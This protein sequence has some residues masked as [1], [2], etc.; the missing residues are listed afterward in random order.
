M[1]H[2]PLTPEKVLDNSTLPTT[3]SSIRVLGAT[4]TRNGFLRRIFDPIIK[5]ANENDSNLYDVLSDVSNG[6]N[7]LHK[8]GEMSR[9]DGPAND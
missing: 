9:N 4:N 3:I 2:H 1:T 6:V 7:K 8:L 5:K